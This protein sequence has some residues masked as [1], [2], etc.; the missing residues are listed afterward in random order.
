[1]IECVKGIV[2]PDDISRHELGGFI[3]LISSHITQARAHTHT[4]T[5]FML[6]ISALVSFI[7]AV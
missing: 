6:M 4:H 3:W 7:D 2:K 5:E 1:M